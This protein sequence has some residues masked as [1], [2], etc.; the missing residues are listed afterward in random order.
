M[1]EISHA[2]AVVRSSFPMKTA[3]E[4]C[5][6]YEAT[7]CVQRPVPVPKGAKRKKEPGGR[8]SE[9]PSAAAS[10]TP[11]VTNPGGSPGV[12]SGASP[13][14]PQ[15]PNSANR[16]RLSE[17]PV[18]GGDSGDKAAR[19]KKAR[20][21]FTGRQIFEL[22]RQFEIKKYLSSS[23]R[24]EMAKLLNVTETQVSAPAAA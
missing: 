7:R 20:T 5:M 18:N 10:P 17:S 2:Y 8:E 21:T 16:A 15:P 9:Q 14:A 24:A 12:P 13:G 19:K 3:P 11:A 23:E 6:G 4:A 1:C 22:E